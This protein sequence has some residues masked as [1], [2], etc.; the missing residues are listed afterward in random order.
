MTAPF[1]ETGVAYLLLH[2][3]CGSCGKRG[4]PLGLSGA[5]GFRGYASATRRG[6]QRQTK[7]DKNLATGLPVAARLMGVKDG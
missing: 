5:H 6:N 7:K 2:W 3:A 4:Q 1:L